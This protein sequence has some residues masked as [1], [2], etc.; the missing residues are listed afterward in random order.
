[1]DEEDTFRMLK[2]ITAEEAEVI[3]QKVWVETSAEMQAAGEDTSGGI[4]VVK[5]RS[6]VDA[7]LKPYGWSHDKLFKFGYWS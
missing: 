4:P 5:L 7:A 6:R 3:F 1:M 2:S